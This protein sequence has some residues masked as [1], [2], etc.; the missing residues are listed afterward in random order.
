M[1]KLEK[2]EE[3]FGACIGWLFANIRHI[4]F[5]NS[6]YAK[7]LFFLQTKFK[8]GFFASHQ[9][10]KKIHITEIYM[11]KQYK[12]SIIRLIEL[13]NKTKFDDVPLKGYVASMVIFLFFDENE[14][15]KKKNIVGISSE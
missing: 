10:I 8:G 12:S 5:T 6:C 7:Q 1:R 4:V 15:K 9:I 3:A 2:L 11:K 13:Q 14:K